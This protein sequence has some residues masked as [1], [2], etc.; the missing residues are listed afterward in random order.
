MM[1]SLGLSRA[2]VKVQYNVANRA[3]PPLKPLCKNM[4]GSYIQVIDLGF[5][6]FCG[7]QPGTRS[8][9]STGIRWRRRREISAASLKPLSSEGGLAPAKVM[10]VLLSSAA[11][12]VNTKA[13]INFKKKPSPGGGG[14]SR[15]SC[16]P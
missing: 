7:E 8:A 11:A 16:L 1:A 14:H 13:Y 15:F 4:E 6:K 9:K 10:L 12:T 3:A 5:R 2:P